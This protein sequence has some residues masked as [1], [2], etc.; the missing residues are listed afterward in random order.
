MLISLLIENFR[1]FGD[2]Q[3]LSAVANGKHQNLTEHLVEVPGHDEKIVP[4]IALYGANGAGKSNVVLALAWLG[5][6]FSSDAL[7]GSRYSHAFSTADRPIR[8]VVRFLSESYV[9]EFGLSTVGR[10]VVS[11]WLSEIDRSGR[12]TVIFERG[13]GTDGKAH[14]SY[15][16]AVSKS[17]E[18]MKALQTLGAPSNELFVARL[19]RELSS[20]ERPAPVTAAI[21]WLSNLTVIGADAPYLELGKSLHENR[22]FKAHLEALLRGFGTGIDAL[23]SKSTAARASSELSIPNRDAFDTAPVGAAFAHGLHGDVFVK[24]SS[25]Q[26]EL[27]QI[28]SR[29]ANSDGEQRVLRFADESD[30]TKRVAH[31]APLLF[32]AGNVARVYVID[33]LDRSLH[34]TLVKEFVRE[35]LER[36]TGSRSQLIFT[37]HETHALDQ[38]LLRRDEVWFVEK[39]KDGAS[40]LYSLD[41]FPVRTDLK[42]DRSYLQGRFGAVPNLRSP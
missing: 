17:S 11:E 7:V 12:E 18:K 24:M 19:R 29:H 15:G 14:V 1:S 33:E 13:G 10:A 37:T 25:D 5:E 23:E 30:G 39:N 42:L 16:A 8:I 40:E 38:E 28:M 26:F 31:L 6:L 27:R 41:D 22:P 20:D 32:D 4:V 3:E 35:F 2:E 21:N 36:A 9:L 34:A